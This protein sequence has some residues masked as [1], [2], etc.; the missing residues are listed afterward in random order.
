MPVKR[1]RPEIINRTDKKEIIV[2]VFKLRGRLGAPSIRYDLVGR[3]V[4]KRQ[5][6]FFCRMRLDRSKR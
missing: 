3:V 4:A 6:F 2:A 1:K 5:L